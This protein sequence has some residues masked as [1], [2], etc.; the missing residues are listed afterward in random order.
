MLYPIVSLLVI[1]ALFFALRDTMS[2]LA[3]SESKVRNLKKLNEAYKEREN[4]WSAYV[5]NLETQLH[6]VQSFHRATQTAMLEKYQT[7]VEV[8]KKASNNGNNGNKDNGHK[9]SK[10]NNSSQKSTTSAETSKAATLADLG[11]IAPDEQNLIE[12]WR[13]NNKPESDMVK[14][15]IARRN[16][17]KAV[18]A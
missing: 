12:N 7:I 11:A 10:N 17:P 4:Q 13:K 8:A 9:D 15:L 14:W 18:K 5:D 1:V 2:K 16:Q 6:M 3:I